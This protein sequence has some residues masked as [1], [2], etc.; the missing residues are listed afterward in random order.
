MAAAEAA[1]E[2]PMFPGTINVIVFVTAAGIMADP[3]VIMV[4]VRRLG[5]LGAIAE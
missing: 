1:G 5:M 3:R 2:A 4:D